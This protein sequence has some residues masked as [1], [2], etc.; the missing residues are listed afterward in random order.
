[1]AT[2]RPQKGSAKLKFVPKFDLQTLDCFILGFQS[3]RKMI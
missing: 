3:L 1:M 2:S